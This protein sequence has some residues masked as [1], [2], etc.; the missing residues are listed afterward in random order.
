MSWAGWAFRVGVLSVAAMPGSA[1][2][3]TIQG[4]FS[5]AEVAIVRDRTGGTRQIA[6]RITPAPGWHT[7]WSNP[8]DGGMPPRLSWD[9]PPASPSL[10]FPTPERV[11]SDGM[12][13]FGY[14]RPVTFFAEG[15]SAGAAGLGSG[16]L[17]W[18]VCDGKRCALEQGAFVLD[19]RP[20]PNGNAAV[21]PMPV[22]VNGARWRI[23]RDRASLTLPAQRSGPV[24][25]A[26][27]FPNEQGA[28]DPKARQTL[29]RLQSG[30]WRITL[31]LP[32]SRHAAPSGLLS[33]TYADGIRQGYA[34]SS[35]AGGTDAVG[36]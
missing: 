12:V 10:S 14:T 23:G 28:V 4:Q 36:R 1:F 5:R 9:H 21:Y 30:R 11:A 7:Y 22:P 17:A 27:F 31:R 8:G 33:I 34:I 29:D 35:A 19:S 3:A 6:I 13:T 16:R 20:M 25:S 32:R 26:Y 18:A 24:A 15:G 2:A